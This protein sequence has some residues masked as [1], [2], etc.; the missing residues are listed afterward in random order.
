[1]NTPLETIHKVIAAAKQDAYANNPA[2]WIRHATLILTRITPTVYIDC[3]T[4]L[5]G[6]PTDIPDHGQ[7]AIYLAQYNT[8]HAAHPAL[9]RATLTNPKPLTPQ[10]EAAALWNRYVNDLHTCQAI[11][12]PWAQMPKPKG[13]TM[14]CWLLHRIH[15][16]AANWE[17]QPGTRAEDFRPVLHD[18]AH[19][20]K[21]IV[22]TDLAGWTTPRTIGTTACTNSGLTEGCKLSPIHAKGL[23]LPC[24]DRQRYANKNN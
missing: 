10:H 8:P 5:S 6:H 24:Y 12:P 23:C 15:D 22:L 11:L 19:T 1:M 14:V 20:L 3:N 7:N 4:T 9:R 2:H 17:T 13:P 18:T 21:R 16:T